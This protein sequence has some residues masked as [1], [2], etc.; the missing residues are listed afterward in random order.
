MKNLGEDVLTDLLAKE[1]VRDRIYRYCRAIDRQDIKALR[2]CYWPDG[3]ADQGPVGGPV[4]NFLS[5]AE[6]VLPLSKRGIHQIHNILIDL[7][8]DGIQAESYFKAYS[9][10]ADDKGD[11]HQSLVMGRYIDWFVERDGQWRI[12]N[13]LVVYDWSQELPQFETT[14]QERFGRRQPIGGI[15]PNDPVY[16]T[17]R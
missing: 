13:R 9:L 1:A 3:T 4:E 17:G 10:R 6:K 2:E 12:L 15:F 5:W 14:E 11:L 16:N 7:K 8:P